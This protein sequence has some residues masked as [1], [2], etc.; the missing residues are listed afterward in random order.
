[1]RILITGG[2]GLVGSSLIP[3][4]EAKGHSF[5]QFVRSPRQKKLDSILWDF[6]QPLENLEALEGLGAAI[7]LA[8]ESVASGRWNPE[9]KSRIR[10]SRVDSTR[11]LSEA[12]S[13]LK[14]PPQVFLCASATGYYGNRGEE[15]VNESSSAG[16]GFLAEVCQEWESACHSAK[17]KGIRLGHLRF[18]I[19]LSKKGGALHKMLPPFKMGLGG[20]LG[21][22][23]QWISW[24]SLDDTIR[25][26]EFVLNQE[27]ISGPV[28]F[29]SPHPVTNGVWTQTLGKVLHR[30]TFLKVPAFAAKI[31]FGEFAEEALLASTRVEP[32]VLG[33][34]GFQFLD[35]ELEGAFR[36]ILS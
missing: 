28:N 24:M 30:P 1:M 35:P 13:K 25:G 19:L 23:K 3:A 11:L 10:T 31:A 34:G 18:G 17:E 8:G 9:K 15:L 12:F 16:E 29:V 20:R 6:K 7:H 26:I 2:S 5:V 21:D 36:R 32:K 4:L 22:G 27:K 14:R 33:D